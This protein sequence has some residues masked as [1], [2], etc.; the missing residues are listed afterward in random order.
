M[1]TRTRTQQQLRD[2]LQSIATQAIEAKRM[3]PT[4]NENLCDLIDAIDNDVQSAIA[5]IKQLR[6]VSEEEGRT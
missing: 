6:G 2:R 5:L 3:D 4:K 1:K